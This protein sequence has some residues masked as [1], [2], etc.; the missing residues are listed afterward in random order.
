[1]VRHPH[2]EQTQ[3]L[4]LAIVLLIVA[5]GIT[6]MLI[7]PRNASEAGNRANFNSG[8]ISDITKQQEEQQRAAFLVKSGGYAGGLLAGTLSEVRDFTQADYERALKEK[9]V[10]LLYFY[11]SWCPFCRVEVKEMYHA[12]EEL[13][14]NDVIA[15]RVNYNDLETDADEVALAKN[16]GVKYQ[17]TKVILKDG[18]VALK[19]GVQWN[20]ERYLQELQ[21]AIS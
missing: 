1:M 5:L 15:F 19:D 10:V 11:A 18:R 14:R 4:W 9:N 21:S 3:W 20:K 12:F 13:N 7:Q 6:S 8:N 17:H 16:F 2:A